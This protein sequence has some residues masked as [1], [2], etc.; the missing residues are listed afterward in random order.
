MGAKD[1][2]RGAVFDAV[3]RKSGLYHNFAKDQ[4]DGIG[5]LGKCGRSEKKTA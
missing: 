3:S 2:V 4:I 5:D 1:R